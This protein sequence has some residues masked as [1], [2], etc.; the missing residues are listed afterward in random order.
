M[1]STD[2]DKWELALED[3]I[4]EIK[5]CQNDKD[6]KSCLGCDKLNDCELRDSYVK[7]VYESM[8]KG[9]SGGFEF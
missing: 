4:I 3:K 2:M 9:E 8:S 7:A 1:S 6:L 5:E